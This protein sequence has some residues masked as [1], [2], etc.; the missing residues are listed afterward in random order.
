MKHLVNWIEIPAKDIARAKRFYSAI[1]GV[2]FHDMDVGPIKYAIFPA[3]DRHNCGALAQGDNY[4][5]GS[6]GPTIYLDGGKDLD[7]VLTK[8]EKAGGKITLKKMLLSDVAGYI[9]MF[10]DSEGN[11]IGLHNPK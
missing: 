1:L 6:S 10:T 9:G 8:V 3:E 2:E 7:T 5:P 4:V 11:S